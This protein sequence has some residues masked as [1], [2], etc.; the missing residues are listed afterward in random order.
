MPSIYLYKANS[1]RPEEKIRYEPK[2]ENLSAIDLMRFIEKN[3]DNKFKLP[4]NLKELLSDPKK[5]KSATNKSKE[6]VQIKKVDPK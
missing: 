3:V 6:K 2:G 1:T 4:S 5:I